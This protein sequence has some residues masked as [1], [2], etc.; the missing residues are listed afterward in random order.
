[1]YFVLKLFKDKV[2]K[3]GT[4][5]DIFVRINIHRERLIRLE[6][7]INHHIEVN[8]TACFF[9]FAPNKFGIF[10]IFRTF[11]FNEN[12]C[13]SSVDYRGSCCQPAP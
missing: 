9:V 12:C 2:L 5:L 11:A 6:H 3:I 13:A 7:A 4:F 10:I 1:M 8:I